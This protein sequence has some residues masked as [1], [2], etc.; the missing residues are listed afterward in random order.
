MDLSGVTG[1]V[2][3][4]ALKRKGIYYTLEN[5]PTLVGLPRGGRRG[6]ICRLIQ[7]EILE[8]LA[9]KQRFVRRGGLITH[10]LVSS[11][12]NTIVSGLH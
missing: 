11:Q 5:T 8:T 7:P 9:R 3:L 1:G 6:D 12:Y 2:L 4:R 10:L